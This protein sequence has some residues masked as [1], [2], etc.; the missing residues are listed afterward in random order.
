MTVANRPV[1]SHVIE[2]FPI[3]VSFVIALGYRGHLVREFLELAYP[4]REFVFVEVSPFEGPGSGLGFSLLCSRPYLDKPFVFCSC[5]TITLTPVPLPDHNW[6]G[7][8]HVENLSQFRTLQV[9]RNQ[10]TAIYEKGVEAPNIKAYIGLAGIHDYDRFWNTMSDGGQTAIATGEAF[11]MTALI[12]NGMRAYPFQ[13]FDTGNLESLNQTREA[14]KQKDGPNIL[15]KPNEAIWFVNGSVIKFST[16][17]EFIKHRVQRGKILESYCPAIQNFTEHM[18]QYREVSGNVLSDIVTLPLFERLLDHCERFW[19][20]APLDAEQTHIFRKNCLS[21]YRDKTL[22]RI[23]LFYRTFDKQDG[24]EPIN[25][26]QNPTLH[27]LLDKIDWDWLSNG[28]PGR[29]HGDLH[30]ENI[31]YSPREDRFTFLDWRQDFNGDL[32]VGDI[33]YDLAKLYHGLI[34]SHELIGRNLFQVNWRSDDIRYDFLRKQIHVE[35]EQMFLGYL[36]SHGYSVKRTTLL[37]ALIFLNIA[38]LHHFPYSLLLYCLG[39]H[40]LHNVIETTG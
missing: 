20:R 3:D 9:E 7:Y 19:K 33:Y 37:T 24:N 34:I 4:T 26:K 5:D 1:I 32:E 40:M 10:T 29:F 25:G 8:S 12:G 18:Y 13:W 15:D 30:F 2:Q 27:T 17:I 14:L 36:A 39:K 38:G 11:G 35:C 23:K 16:D 6:M 31:L 21:F 22:E 28:L